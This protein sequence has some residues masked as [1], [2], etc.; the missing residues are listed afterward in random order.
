MMNSIS[1]TRLAAS[2]TGALG[3]APPAQAEPG[4]PQVHTLVQDMLGKSADRLMIYNPD[5]IAIGSV[6]ARCE[7]LFAQEMRRVLE[8][9]A[10]PQSLAACRIVPA[11]LGDQIGDYAALSLAVEAAGR[12]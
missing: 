8:R 4:I 1:M 10:L 7:D 9:E 2:V 3:V 5:C 6:Y 12:A 11:Q